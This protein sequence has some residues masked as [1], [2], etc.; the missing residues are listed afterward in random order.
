M[1]NDDVTIAAPQR[2]V[3]TP[4]GPEVLPPTVDLPETLGYRVKKVLLGPPLVTSELHNEKLS[5]SIALGVLAPDCISS[6]AYGT[7]QMLTVLVPTFGVLGFALVMP[8]TGVILALLLL[9]TLSYR[10]VVMTYTR[11]GGSYVVARENFG[12]RVAQVAAV[13]LLIDYIVTVA[14]QTAAGTDAV[15]SLLQLLF[16]TNID[17][18]KLYITLGVVCLLCYGN[19]RGIREAGKAFSLP[20]YLFILATG[21]TVIFGIFRLVTGTLPQLSDADL[22][23][24]GVIHI[25]ASSGSLMTFASMFVLARAFA[26]GGSS[27]TGLEAISN[28]V[29]AFREP[30]GNNAR[31]TLVI[32]SAT[33]GALVLGVSV[34]A[35]KTHAVPFS[36][37]S[38]TVLAQE[39]HLVFGQSGF[40][41]VM[42]AFVQVAT[43]LILYTGGNTSFNGFPFLASFVAEDS[44]LPR[45]LTIRGHRLAFSNG[46][47]VLTGVSLILLLVTDGDLSRL[48]SLYAIGVF[49]GFVMAASGLVK[50]H[51]S[52]QE[53]NRMAKVVVNA[54]AAVASAAVVVIFAVTKFTEGA[55]TVV[56]IFPIGVW[57]LIRTNSRYR[58]ESAALA[59]APASAS[60]P[61]RD[62]SA[63]FVLVDRLDLSAIRALHHGR[64]LRPTELRAVHFMVDDKHAAR[65][66]TEWEQSRA[67]DVPLEIVDCPDRRLRRATAELAAR[68]TAD[69]R[70]RVTLVIPRRAYGTF[71]GRLL[72]ARVGDRIAGAASR[73]PNVAATIVPFDVSQAIDDMDTVAREG[74]GVAPAAGIGAP[75]GGKGV[76]APQADG[77]SPDTTC[78]PGPRTDGVTHM[79]DLVWRERAGVEGQVRSVNLTPVSG[80]PRLEC[81][82][83]D[84]TGGITLIFYGRRDVPG[85]SPGVRLRAEGMVGNT[86]GRLTIAN[87]TYTLLPTTAESPVEH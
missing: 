11:A 38:P 47:I 53:K 82:L 52:R 24:S 49:T 5:K 71:I 87:P 27:L 45:Q 76:Q 64:S 2:P 30:Q 36:S 21:L 35:W 8:V 59:A 56:V 68:A 65:L 54:A 48:V 39:A 84:E 58:A 18:E 17:S 73:L 46:I 74:T 19:L 50:Y 26:N 42:F 83:Y 69:G 72:H 85:I 63:V 70:T 40:G 13:A 75:R 55:W 12:P 33:L 61:N 79:R 81:R 86:D 66:R 6:S 7:E 20:T 32:M 23:A 77:T 57:A 28:G 14:V 43:A 62:R 10:D 34:L 1:Q 60:L 25:G 37:G 44:F 80:V 22:H 31:R 16:H 78:V 41:S 15:A 3:G 51:W 67:A 4:T 9:L 29:S